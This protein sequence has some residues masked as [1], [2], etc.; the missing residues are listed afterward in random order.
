MLTWKAIG[1]TTPF[2]ASDCGRFVV[3]PCPKGYTASRF[4]AK[5]DAAPVE[6]SEV[7]PTCQQAFDW[8]EARATLEPVLSL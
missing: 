4:D 2:H 5:E 6:E 3:E 1:C 8:C 7:L